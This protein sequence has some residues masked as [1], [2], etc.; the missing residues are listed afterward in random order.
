MG[1]KKREKS[2]KTVKMI[3]EGDSKD[4]KVVLWKKK[5]QKVGTVQILRS[6]RAAQQLQ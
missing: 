5:G 4:E 2:L 1:G 6:T 3:D